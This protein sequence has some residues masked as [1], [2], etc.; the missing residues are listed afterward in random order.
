MEHDFLDLQTKL[1]SEVDSYIYRRFILLLKKDQK[2]RDEFCSI[3]HD[4]YLLNRFI[5]K[6]GFSF[7]IT[8]FQSFVQQFTRDRLSKRDLVHYNGWVQ[9]K[10]PVYSLDD[11]DINTSIINLPF[12][13]FSC[14]N[15]NLLFAGNIVVYQQS[16]SIQK[17]I[18]LIKST[19]FEFYPIANLSQIH[20]H[21]DYEVFFN[22]S[23]AAY[24]TLRANKAIPQLLRSMILELGMDPK[25]VLWEWPSFRIFFPSSCF[26]YGA[27]KGSSTSLLSPHRDTWFGAPQN[28]FNFWGPLETLPMESSLRIFS[29]HHRQSLSNTSSFFDVWSHELGLSFPPELVST[30]DTSKYHSPHLKV[31]DVMLFSSHALHAS[32][33]LSFNQTRVTFELRMLNHN[34]QALKT[35]PLNVDYYGNGYI[36]KNLFNA[37][38]I[39]TNY[40]DGMPL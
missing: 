33:P 5:N 22:K 39:E 12:G 1:F 13:S 14:F 28:Q 20:L 9:C 6:L 25:D 24:Q 11:H 30:I 26:R 40:Y 37:H 2:V 8:E 17:I 38:G 34:D 36:Y 3:L 16:P 21:Y 15:R 10:P 23:I 7:S 19:L 4:K 32:P 31:G 29:T 27:Y 35:L 18:S